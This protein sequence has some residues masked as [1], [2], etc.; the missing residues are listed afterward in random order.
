VSNDEAGTVTFHLTE[1]DPEFLYK[2]ATPQGFPVPA[3]TPMDE[4]Q[5]RAGVPGTGPYMLERPDDG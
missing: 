5:I 2:L 4:E 3:S 1:P